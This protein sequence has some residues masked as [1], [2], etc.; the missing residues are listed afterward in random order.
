MP[1]RFQIHLR[2][3]GR[4]QFCLVD[5]A[6]VHVFFRDLPMSSQDFHV[7]ILARKPGHRA[8]VGQ[9][10][11][12]ARLQY[13][14]CFAEK[15]LTC[16][17]VK[18]ALERED[19]VEMRIGKGQ[20]RGVSFDKRDR[21]AHTAP[22]GA[23]ASDTNLHWRYVHAR[24][25]HRMICVVPEKI[26]IAEAK[27]YVQHLVFGPK[28]HRSGQEISERACRFVES[29]GRVFPVS[30]IEIQTFDA[31]GVFVAK[32][33]VK[34]LR[35][36]LER[37]IE[38]EKA[39]RSP[40]PKGVFHVRTGILRI[41]VAPV[42]YP[43]KPRAVRVSS[44]FRV[45]ALVQS[46][47]WQSHYEREV[48]ASANA[49]PGKR[50]SIRPR[51]TRARLL[52]KRGDLHRTENMNIEVWPTSPPASTAAGQNAKDRGSNARPGA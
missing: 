46:S 6:V 1:D 25:P 40:E 52:R 24:D 48:S 12:T 26:L 33:G 18:S 4:C 34:L 38:R 8:K 13:A 5:V 41:H 49:E 17:E 19:H 15:G 43:K 16:P 39:K 30:E 14:E 2:E 36:P 10:K 50:E 51:P 28:L 44:A 9:S 23:L 37:K 11:S 21:I 32:R 20:A 35:T 31:K 45:L 7:G 27:P 47:V 3:T 22:R 29:L 42:R